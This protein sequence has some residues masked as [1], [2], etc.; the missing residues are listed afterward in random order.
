VRDAGVP[1]QL[2]ELAVTLDPPFDLAV[3]SGR[4]SGW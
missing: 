1:P 3:S 4:S 2:A